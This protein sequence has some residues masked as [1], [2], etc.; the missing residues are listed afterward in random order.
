MALGPRTYDVSTA[1]AAGVHN[2][3]NHVVLG[4]NFGVSARALWVLSDASGSRGLRPRRAGS[5]DGWSWRRACRG[6]R[7]QLQVPVW[8]QG[9]VVGT[10]VVAGAGVG[11][12]PT[13]GALAGAWPLIVIMLSCGL[14]ASPWA[15]HSSG[16][17]DGSWVSRVQVHNWSGLAAGEPRGA[18]K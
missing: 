5:G 4:E 16:V 12:G 14:G 9:P 7:G 1:Q 2:I 17:S 18:G 13:A 8:W 6:C 3:D 15:M 10:P 11:A